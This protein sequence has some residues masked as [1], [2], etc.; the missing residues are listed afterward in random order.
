[1]ISMPLA[2]YTGVRK[3][4][5]ARRRL[6]LFLAAVLKLTLLTA[7][8]WAPVCYL[9]AGNMPFSFSKKEG[10]RGGQLAMRWF[11]RFSYAIPGLSIGVL[12]IHGLA[13]LLAGLKG[14]AI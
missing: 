2:I 6:Y 12:L 11:W 1:M 14:N 3:L 4:R 8:L 9:L 5:Q 10:F 7:I 13:S